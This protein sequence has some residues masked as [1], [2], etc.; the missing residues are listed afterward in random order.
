VRALK[1]LTLTAVVAGFVAWLVAFSSSA[2]IVFQAAR[3]LGAT[4]AQVASWMLALGVAIAATSIPLSLRYRIPVATAWSTPGAALLVTSVD[5]VTMPQAIGAFMVCAALIVAV[6][7]TGW[8]EAAMRRVPHTL[9][10]AMLAGVLLRF[11]LEAFGA[12]ETEFVLVVSMLLVYLV[13]RRFIPRYA[14]PAV[15]VTGV[16][17][18]AAQGHLVTGGLRFELARPVFV[19][20]EFSW[21]A[22][23]SVALPLFVVTMAS[24]NVPGVAVL[25][26]AGYEPPVSP[27]VT[28]TGVSALVLAPFGAFAMNLAAIVAAITMG[29]DA[30]EDPD[31]R[32]MAAVSFGAFFLVFGLL[33]ATVASVFAMFPAAMVVTLAGLAL[34][35]T[36]AAG[37]DSALKDEAR[38]E[39]AIITFLVTASGL[40]LFGIGAAFWG[41]VAGLLASVVLHAPL[42]GADSGA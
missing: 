15:L 33:G 2:V 8:F 7:A 23:V 36:I 16:A 10:A 32:Y 31:K 25:R 38:R 11:A 13:A 6:G 12:L 39:P 5:G 18:V 41:I 35:N 21:A 30:A 14:V 17:I 40:Q 29:E 9:G 37:L 20:P 3:A 26:S 4:D 27:L 19:A 42:R 22:I 28:W 24:Q 1:D 34:M